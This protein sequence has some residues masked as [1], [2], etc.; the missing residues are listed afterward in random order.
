MLQDVASL[1]DCHSDGS[2]GV[3]LLIYAPRVISYTPRV[4]SYAPRVISYAPRVVSYAPR[5]HL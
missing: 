3:I 1:N 5:E 4:I 2:R